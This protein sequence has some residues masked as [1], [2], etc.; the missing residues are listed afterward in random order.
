[1]TDAQLIREIKDGDVQLYA[2]I[3]V[4]YERKIRAFVLHIIKATPI[5]H[6][7]DDITQ[8]AFFSA[9]HHLAHFREG[10]AAFSTWLYTI[11]RNRAI[12]ELRKRALADVSIDDEHV[13]AP[14]S[15]D[16]SS[17]EHVALR[18]EKISLVREAIAQLPEKQRTAL[19]L[20][21]Y[22][23]LD[24]QEIAN[25][26]ATTVSAVKSLLFRALATVRQRLGH[27]VGHVEEAGG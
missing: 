19:V 11:A 1:M 15:A 3:V 8:D 2:H 16:W 6:L 26:L 13:D 22:E 20:R 7:V 17:P 12:S 25:V 10:E 4:R 5:A 18:K 27:Y 21:E 24:Y 23:G 14:V 9:F